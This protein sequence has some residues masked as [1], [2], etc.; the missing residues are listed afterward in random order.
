MASLHGYMTL[1]LS[2]PI[3]RSFKEP[4]A[5]HYIYCRRHEPK[6]AG[7]DDDRTLFVVNVPID[8]T[9]T[10]LRHLFTSLGGGRVE[11]V[12]F[13]GARS[14]SKPAIAP[15][16]V[17]RP[18]PQH[19]QKK[20]RKRD[21]DDDDDDDS[22]APSD[23]KAEAG[24]L[25]DTR[26]RELHRSGGTALVVFVD[27]PALEASVKA[28]ARRAG[29]AAAAKWVDVAEDKVPALGSQRYL[30]HHRLRYPPPTTLQSVVD[31]YMTRYNALEAQRARQAKRL[32]QEPDE[33]GFITVT[34]GGRMGPARQEEADAAAE[35]QKSKAAN[36]GLKDF[37]RFQV[38]E[39]R[40]KAQGDL[41]RRF[42]ED[43]RKVLEMKRKRGRF[44]VSDV[45]LP[46]WEGMGLEM[47]TLVGIKP[48]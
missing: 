29:K 33:D 46:V 5:V 27:K 38:R 34:R 7:P 16:V 43:R 21:D 15:A 31:A 28:V 17:V 10:H 11:L 36:S 1:S 25:P 37:Y 45:Y 14:T 32:R 2:L 39:E 19:Q 30:T 3:P 40:K 35:R 18:K 13:E 48:E 41:L 9:E 42:E 6:V 20:K 44:K 26:D 12:K 23:T 47:L 24:D 4:A 8:A 22:G